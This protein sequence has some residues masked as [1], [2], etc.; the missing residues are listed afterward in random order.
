MPRLSVPRSV[1]TLWL[2]QLRSMAGMVNGIS[3]HT[4]STEIRSALTSARKERY[5]SSHRAS[6]QWQVSDLRKVW[7]TRLSILVRNTLTVSMV[8]F[9]TTLHIPHTT[10]RWVRFLHILLDIRRMQVSSATI[11]LG[12]SS[13]RLLP[14]VVTMLGNSSVR[15]A[16]CTSR[17][18]LSTRL[19]H[20]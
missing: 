18:R 13:V 19:S 4:T 6:A 5:L 11:I 10:L 7:L 17:I 8:W 9:S 20:M 2:R 3:V 1:L 15:S 16:L 14:D 12:L